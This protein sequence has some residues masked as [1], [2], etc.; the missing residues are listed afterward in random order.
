VTFLE[1]LEVV[2]AAD[3]IIRTTLKTWANDRQHVEGM[4]E[5]IAELDAQY[6][7]FIL[8]DVAAY[9]RRDRRER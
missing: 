3:R 7:A 4:K 2:R 6:E 5:E 9:N 1:R 8:R